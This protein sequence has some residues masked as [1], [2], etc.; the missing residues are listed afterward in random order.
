LLAERAG[1]RSHAR[2]LSAFLGARFLGYLLFAAVAWKLGALASL[3]P[4]A[5]RAAHGRGQR[6]AR[7]RA[8]LVCIFRQTH[9]RP[10]VFGFE[11][12]KIGATKNRG[13]A[14]RRRW[15]C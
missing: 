12:V 10:D 9:L 2:Y 4:G 13:V 7:L 15:A 6:A 8:A 1:V 5:A 3:L 11:L 14:G